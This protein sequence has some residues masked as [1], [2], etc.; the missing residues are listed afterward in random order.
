MTTLNLEKYTIKDITDFCGC[1]RPVILKHLK[2]GCYKATTFKKS[3][4]TIKGYSLSIKELREL[5]KI[6]QNNKNEVATD[7]NNCSTTEA[8]K[9]TINIDYAVKYFETKEELIQLK[10]DIKLLE[11]KHNSKEGL[12]IKEINDLKADKDLINQE[13][14][15]LKTDKIRLYK[16]IAGLSAGMLIVLTV[17]IMTFIR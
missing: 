15:S 5:K 11:D 6:I 13:L 9:S 17:L 2:R 4:R 12:Y 1:S 7:E 16:I 14:T 10:S 8:P 3:G